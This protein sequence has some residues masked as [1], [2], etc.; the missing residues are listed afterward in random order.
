M[1]KHNACIAFKP[2]VVSLRAY[3]CSS[4]SVLQIQKMKLMRFG[5]FSN[6]KEEGENQES[7]QSGTTPFQEHHVKK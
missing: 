5:H 6:N 7:I 3:T 4:L 2:D 1:H